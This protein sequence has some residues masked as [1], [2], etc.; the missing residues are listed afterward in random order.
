MFETDEDGT[1]EERWSL[2]DMDDMCRWLDSVAY[3]HL[4]LIEELLIHRDCPEFG[5]Q[6]RL[7]M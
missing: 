3:K 5:R 6:V 4:E 1:G 7:V 2:P